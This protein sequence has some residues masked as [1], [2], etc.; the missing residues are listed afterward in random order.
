MGRIMN[1]S[2]LLASLAGLVCGVGCE[3]SSDTATSDS[4]GALSVSPAAAYLSASRV[5]V[6]SFA[7]SGGDSNYSW[8]VA[9]T[10]LGVL[11]ASGT[12]ALYQSSTTAGTNT[13]AVTDGSGNTGYAAVFQE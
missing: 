1:V 13:V 6:V 9:S 10:S 2:L 7:V 3:L 12:T 11:Y 4:A 8:S 5:T